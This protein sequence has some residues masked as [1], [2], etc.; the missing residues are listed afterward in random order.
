M[1]SDLFGFEICRKQLWGNK[2]LTD[3][4][5]IIIPKL[6]ESDVFIING[7]LSEVF[8]DCQI[9][10]NNISEISLIT[11][12]SEEFIKFRINNLLK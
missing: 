3:L 7:E 8:N 1:E 6:K 4:G 11:N 5:C 12:F 2:K 10:I 9:I